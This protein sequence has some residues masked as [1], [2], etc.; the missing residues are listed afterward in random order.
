MIRSAIA[1]FLFFLAA[2]S[3]SSGPPAALAPAVAQRSE[4]D[5][6]LDGLLGDWEMT[7]AVMGE[8]VRYH[9]TVARTLDGAW[10]EFHLIDAAKPPQYEARIFTG[11]DESAQDYVAH[12]LDGFGA[13]GARVAALGARAGDEL[14]LEFPYAQG[15]FRN[16]WKRIDDDSWTL[17]IDAENADG[18]WSEFAHYSIER[19]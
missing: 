10:V 14:R 2:C 17:R 18:S 5:I 6:F 19:R 9:A 4:N 8:Q 12:W 7:G 3:H 1:S 15:E 13:G 16:L 11:A